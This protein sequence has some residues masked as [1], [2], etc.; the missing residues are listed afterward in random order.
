MSEIRR[1]KAIKM[2]VNGGSVAS[3]MREAGYSKAY[4]K[5]SDK[6][7]K[8]KKVQKEIKP[9]LKRLEEERDQALER[10]KGIRNKAK[11]KDLIDSTEKLTKLIQLLSGKSTE[12]LTFVDYIKNV[13]RP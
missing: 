7:T 2:V 6:F 9:I 11:Y 5:H 4:S 8:T 12:N 10:A 13:K 3:A 1:K